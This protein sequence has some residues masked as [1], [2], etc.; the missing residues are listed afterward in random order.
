M[1]W[2]SPHHGGR[3]T[4]HRP[5]PYRTQQLLDKTEGRR[6]SSGGICNRPPLPPTIGT[7]SHSLDGLLDN[8]SDIEQ[9]AT[10]ATSV[11]QSS[12]NLI[13]D[14]NNVVRRDKS[15]IK[16]SS[17][18]RKSRSLEHLIDEQQQQPQQDGGDVT[19]SLENLDESDNNGNHQTQII[20]QKP[21][22]E[23]NCEKNE[24]P[25]PRQSPE[26]T[27]STEDD[28]EDAQSTN[29]VQSSTTSKDTNDKGKN[30]T[31]INKA[32]KKVRSLMKK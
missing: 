29:S 27:S 11:A 13:E 10:D 22:S 15:N 5:L 4:H 25:S 31:F 19:K 18:K 17:H 14:N 3:S 21:P 16:N 2:L 8:T 30:K 6:G 1:Q 7:R 23:E 32:V 24:K 9:Q 12:Q 26:G 28:V 20:I